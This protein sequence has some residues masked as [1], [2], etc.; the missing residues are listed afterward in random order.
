MNA[1]SSLLF[2]KRMFSY[3]IKSHFSIYLHF[4]DDFMDHRLGMN[5]FH[6]HITKF[7]QSFI[8]MIWLCMESSTRNSN[9]WKCNLVWSKIIWLKIWR[10]VLRGEYLCTRVV[11]WVKKKK[12]TKSLTLVELWWLFLVRHNKAKFGSKS[13]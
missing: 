11:V 4:V 12:N 6:N 7:L 5:K 8:F 10:D 13:H 2:F 3:P 1:V 9:I